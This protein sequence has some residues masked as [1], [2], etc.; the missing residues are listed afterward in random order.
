MDKVAK[1]RTNLRSISQEFSANRL[2]F[3]VFSNPEDSDGNT[4]F[5]VPLVGRGATR[6]VTWMGDN[7]ITRTNNIGQDKTQPHC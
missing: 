3:Q 4:H 5:M 1:A 6:L 2:K 7:E